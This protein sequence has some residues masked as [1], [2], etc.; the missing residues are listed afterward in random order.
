MNPRFERERPAY[1]RPD[2]RLI[3][4]P[5]QRETYYEKPSDAWCRFRRSFTL[6]AAPEEATAAIFADTRYRLYVNGNEVAS[7]PCRSDP[8]WQ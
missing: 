5:A 8:R 7:G 2:A 3:W 1:T 4:D 6:D